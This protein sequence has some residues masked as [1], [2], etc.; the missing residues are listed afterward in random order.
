MF[1]DNSRSTVLSRLYTGRLARGV[2]N[3]LIEELTARVGELPPFPAPAWF[4]SHLKQA[5][6]EAGRTDLM[7]LYAGQI[8]P[9]LHH[10]TAPALMDDLLSAFS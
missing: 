10:R 3:R 2:P 5:C 8:A 9:S 1:S 4:L 7:S 6:L